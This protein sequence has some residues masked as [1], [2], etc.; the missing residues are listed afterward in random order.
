S[1][2][3][4]DAPR[5]DVR[6]ILT[7]EALGKSAGR[8]TESAVLQDERSQG[9]EDVAEAFLRL[10]EP[11]TKLLQVSDGARH[12]LRRSTLRELDPEGGVGEGLGD[13]VMQIASEPVPLLLR[14]LHDTES[15][16]GEVGG[17]LYVLESDPGRGRQ[18]HR[19]SLVA[20]AKRSIR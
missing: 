17:E 4:L 10:E 12:V 20:G 13:A 14:D 18:G 6:T 8:R 7:V 5:D 15:L 19:V 11:V 1:P 9:E 16:G 2:I 3:R